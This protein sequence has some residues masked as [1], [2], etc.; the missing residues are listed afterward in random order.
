MK[1]LPRDVCACVDEEC[2]HIGCRS[3]VD[4]MIQETLHLGNIAH[5]GLK[6]WYCTLITKPQ[7]A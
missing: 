2:E 3:V 7:F 5:G 1:P 6:I 4:L